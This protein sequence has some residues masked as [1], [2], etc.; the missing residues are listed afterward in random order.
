MGAS[1]L[2]AI[3]PG[4]DNILVMTESLTKSAKNG[5][6]LALGMNSGV[7]IHTIAAATGISLIL[8]Q[9]ELAF[10]IVKILGALYLLYLAYAAFVE[11]SD[12]GRNVEDIDVVDVVDVVV[13]NEEVDLAVAENRSTDSIARLFKQGFVMNVLNPKVSLF[14]IALLPQFLTDDGYV[15]MYQM[16]ILGAIFMII[17]AI[18][19]S[20]IALLAGHLKG[21][22]Q[23]VSFWNKMKWLK[24]GVLLLIASSLLFF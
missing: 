3:M 4:P 10:T 15:T 2:L 5:V 24:I 18:V 20:A 7:L 6:A 23:D 21:Y 9:S 13:K 17:G 11:D 12:V 14:F 16:I 19:F 1:F 22:I 8:Q